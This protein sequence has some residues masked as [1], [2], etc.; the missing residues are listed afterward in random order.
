MP[1]PEY[2]YAHF[3]GDVDQCL[4]K[5][6][7]EDERVYLLSRRLSEKV[8]EITG[9][10]EAKFDEYLRVVAEHIIAERQARSERKQQM[11]TFIA[12]IGEDPTCGGIF[13]DDYDD[14]DGQD[15][16]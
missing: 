7:D 6:K 14:D 1:E 2:S 10:D 11:R 4:D 9:D 5:A 3:I 8:S 12:M 16:P 13:P 15:S